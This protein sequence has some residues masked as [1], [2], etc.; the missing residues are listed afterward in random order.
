[1][2][3]FALILILL[4]AS[5][6]GTD[7][8]LNKEPMRQVITLTQGDGSIKLEG[9]SLIE[10][11]V[12][13]MNMYCDLCR[14]N[15]EIIFEN[16]DFHIRYTNIPIDENKIEYLKGDLYAAFYAGGYPLHSDHKMYGETTLENGIKTV[17]DTDGYELYKV[18]YN[19]NDIRVFNLVREYNILINSEKPVEQARNI[20]IAPK[21][22]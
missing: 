18:Y 10:N 5:A 22:N 19:D 7:F 4:T 15:A 2:K 16:G 12:V 6:C 8:Y 11:D 13:R 9:K 3:R 21:S 20:E 14:G 17:K 1:M